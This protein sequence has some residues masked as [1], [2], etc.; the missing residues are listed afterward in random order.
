M[1]CKSL[2]FCSIFAGKTQFYET[3]ISWVSLPVGLHPW[4]TWDSNTT[5]DMIAHFDLVQDCKRMRGEGRLLVL[6]P[7]C[8]S[9]KTLAKLLQFLHCHFRKLISSSSWIITT[10]V[11]RGHDSSVGIATYY[12]VDSSGF[13]TSWEWDFSQTSL[14]PQRHTQSPCTIDNAALCS[15]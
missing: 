7:F 8:V 15:G 13:E 12:G 6:K 4:H 11:T 10:L 5:D 2:C 14:P 1:Q 9:R 3:V